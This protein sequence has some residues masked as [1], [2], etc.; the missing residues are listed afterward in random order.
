M[1]DKIPVYLADLTHTGPVLSSNVHPLAAG[2]VGAQLLESLPDLVDVE[3][4]KYPRDLSA[5]V[6]RRTPTIA[7]FSNYSWNCN[8]SYE[9]AVRL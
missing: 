4:F 6:S 8:I 3:L 5:A 1:R 7:G 2:L 9:Y